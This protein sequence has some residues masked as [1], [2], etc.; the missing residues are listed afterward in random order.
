MGGD[1][2]GISVVEFSLFGAEGISGGEPDMWSLSHN[3]EQ[4]V[5]QKPIFE[6]PRSYITSVLRTMMPVQQISTL[7]NYWKYCTN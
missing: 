5:F 3:S 7:K 4:L 6:C 2:G 1:V